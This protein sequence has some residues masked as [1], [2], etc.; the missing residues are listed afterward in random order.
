MAGLRPLKETVAERLGV[1]IGKHMARSAV[2]TFSERAIGRAPETLTIADMPA[3]LQALRPMLRTLIGAAQC[4]VVLAQI[5][6]D[7]GL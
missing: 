6:R 5:T 3:L 2:K 1:C 4:E 7:V